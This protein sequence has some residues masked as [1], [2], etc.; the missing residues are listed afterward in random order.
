MNMGALVEASVMTRPLTT[1]AISR[2]NLKLVT[3]VHSVSP[4]EFPLLVSV[5]VRV[6]PRCARCAIEA[7]GQV[8]I[9]EVT[10]Q[11]VF[12]DPWTGREQ[13][14]V[15]VGYG[16]GSRVRGRRVSRRVERSRSLLAR[17]RSRSPLY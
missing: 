11:L 14:A 3:C 13:E 10:F 12:H 4:S 7:L 8:L 5:Y 6:R 9:K 15:G 1:Q 16:F 2:P 17:D